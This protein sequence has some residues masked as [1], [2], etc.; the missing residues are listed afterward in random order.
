MVLK[1]QNL[2]PCLTDLFVSKLL[3]KKERIHRFFNIKKWTIY[4]LILEISHLA[5][6]E[7]YAQ[8]C[9]GGGQSAEVDWLLLAT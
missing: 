6:H 5:K 9:A 1:K 7:V 3:E 4:P 2:H 8:I